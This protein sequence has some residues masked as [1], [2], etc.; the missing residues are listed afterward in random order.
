MAQKPVN[1]KKKS[2]MTGMAMIVIVI[3]LIIGILFYK[4][5]CGNAKNFEENGDP[6]QG[7]FLGII[8]KGGFIVPVLFSLFLTVW[9]FFVERLMT[10]SKAKGS[11]SIQS[12]LQKIKFHLSNHDIDSA[13][14]ECDKQK[15]SVANVVNAGL[16]KYAEMK[17]D[18]DATMEQKCSTSP[19]RSKRLQLWKCPLWKG[20]CPS[21]QPSPPSER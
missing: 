4:F 19:K 17:T 20:I 9:V 5:V 10:I 6:K 18:K 13:L 11:G 21:W 7:N 14:K 15:G 1:P 3:N 2:A 8:Y 12:F 16:H